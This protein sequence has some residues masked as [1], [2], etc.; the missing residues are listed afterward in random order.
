MEDNYFGVCPICH[1]TD[2]YLDIGSKYV[3]FCI[4]HRV[5]WYPSNILSEGGDETEAEQCRMSELGLWDFAD[6]EAHYERDQVRSRQYRDNRYRFV[7]P[8]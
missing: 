6:V 8:S 7:P 3:F 1:K 2:G 4:K 5:R